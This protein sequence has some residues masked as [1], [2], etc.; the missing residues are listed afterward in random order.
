MFVE[1]VE[2]N[3]LI[4]NELQFDQYSRLALLLNNIWILAKI[5]KTN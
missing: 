3:P 4:Y 1:F 2:M 5:S